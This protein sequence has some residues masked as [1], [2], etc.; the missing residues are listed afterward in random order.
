[1]KTCRTSS[2]KQL[3][4]E[5]T[6]AKK[7]ALKLPWNFI[8]DQLREVEDPNRVPADAALELLGGAISAIAGMDP[9]KPI[10][11]AAV[12]AALAWATHPRKKS[13]ILQ[14]S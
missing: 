1:M 8:V 2:P 11:K 6:R 14:S 7:T 5:Y 12:N 10:P 9:N 3:A 13:G 4:A